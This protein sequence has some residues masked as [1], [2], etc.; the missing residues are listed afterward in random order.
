MQD[1]TPNGDADSLIMMP[2]S[3]AYVVGYT[4]YI[5]DISELCAYACGT[6]V[7][8]NR[9]ASTE[10]R[11]YHGLYIRMRNGIKFVKFELMLRSNVDICSF[12]F[13]TIAVLWC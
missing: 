13:G 11:T 12:V 2:N 8:T 5:M 4:V 1:E 7:S 3:A 10:T 9:K 6:N